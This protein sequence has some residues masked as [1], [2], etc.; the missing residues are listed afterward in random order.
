MEDKVKKLRDKAKGSFRF[1]SSWAMR[2]AKETSTR[3][4]NPKKSVISHGKK[5]KIDD[6]I[7]DIGSIKKPTKEKPSTANRLADNRFLDI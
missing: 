1:A 2:Q 3:N 5:V 7:G 6:A 4:S